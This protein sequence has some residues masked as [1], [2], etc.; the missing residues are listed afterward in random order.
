MR[1]ATAI[2]CVSP[3][4]RAT[5]SR[6]RANA[7]PSNP[8]TRATSR[9]T[10]R[11]A[12]SALAGRRAHRR[13][14]RPQLRGRRR[15]QRAARRP[16]V[17]DF[18]SEIVAAQPFPARHMSM[19]S[20]YE[21]GSRAG[22][23]RILRLFRERRLPL[24]VFGVGMA[25]ARNPAVVDAFLADGHEIASHGWR[26]ICTSR[27]TSTSSASTWRSPIDTHHAAHRPAARRLVHRAATARTRG[28]SWSSTAASPTAPTA[29]PTT[30]PTTCRCAR[31]WRRAAA[32]RAVHARRQRHALR[33]P[34]GLQQ[35]R[36][37]L[38]VSQ[39]PFDVLYAEGD[40]R[41]LDAPKM[42]SIGLHC[43]IVGR[44]GRARR[45]RALPRLRAAA[46]RRVGRAA[47]RHRAPLARDASARGGRA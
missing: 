15:E 39:G 43:R 31:A 21:Y 42:M 4:S 27:S 30:C 18:L 34:A 37:V 20:L 1:L 46:R 32:D 7:L 13:A 17:G 36:A 33:H 11:A 26:W 12:A 19:E 25:L 44:P 6:H 2:V 10:A 9:A 47:H 14:V 38:H 45:A 40:P 22:V 3:P 24:T 29:T 8:A 41:G 35:R 5:T 23:W 16:G 28:G